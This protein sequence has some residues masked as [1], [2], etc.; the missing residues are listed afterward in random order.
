MLSDPP[1]TLPDPL[2]PRQQHLARRGLGRCI[3]RSWLPGRPGM[4]RMA[5]RLGS[6]AQAGAV[7]TTIELRGFDR[8]RR[9]GSAASIVGHGALLPS[10]SAGLLDDRGRWWRREWSSRSRRPAGRSGSRTR[11]LGRITGSTSTGLR[12]R[13][14]APDLR[15]APGGHGRPLRLST[16]VAGDR[17]PLRTTVPIPSWNCDAATYQRA[18]EAEGR[19]LGDHIAGRGFSATR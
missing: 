10:V 4:Q 11:R 17:R 12:M 3:S 8:Q 5:W 19:V 2:N 15:F 9:R 1:A 14:D 7:P 6:R 18:I 13:A 16:A